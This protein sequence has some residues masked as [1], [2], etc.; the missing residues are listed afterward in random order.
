MLSTAAIVTQVAKI[1]HWSL[2]LPE[3]I[4]L[5]D[6]GVGLVLF[7]CLIAYAWTAMG[8]KQQRSH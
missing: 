7:G 5:I 1:R 8:E 4:N 6:L 3:T 2:G